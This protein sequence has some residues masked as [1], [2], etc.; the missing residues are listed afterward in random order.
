MRLFVAGIVLW[1]FGLYFRPTLPT[2]P[3]TV[4]HTAALGEQEEVVKLDYLPWTPCRGG[5]G[6]G[7]IPEEWIKYGKGK[8]TIGM[9]TGDRGMMELCTEEGAKEAL[10]VVVGI[11][12][13]LRVWGLGG[14]FNRVLE[15]LLQRK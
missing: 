13:S 4:S 11:L 8:A 5:I 6:G 10:R 7:G 3:N 12:S 2:A 14:E 15:E 9:D 1:G